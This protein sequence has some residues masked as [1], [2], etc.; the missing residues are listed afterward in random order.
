MRL[1]YI[2]RDKEEV[3]APETMAL[4]VTVAVASGAVAEGSLRV[5]RPPRGV[6][7]YF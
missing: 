6:F 4:V 2:R 7:D 3:L 1:E 5:S